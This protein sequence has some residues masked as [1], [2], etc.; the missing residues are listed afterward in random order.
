MPGQW[1]AVDL[2][3][4]VQRVL[5]EES[6]CADGLNVGGELHP[7]F[8]EQEKLVWA[9]L[10]RAELAGRFVEMLCEIGNTADVGSDC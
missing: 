3:S 8:I 2:D 9:N 1:H 6:K 7:L 10:L 4:T 5:V